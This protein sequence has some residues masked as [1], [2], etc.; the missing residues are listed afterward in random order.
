MSEKIAV[1]TGCSKGIGLATAKYLSESGYL[2]YALSRNKQSMDLEFNNIKNIITYQINLLEKLEI[3][4]FAEQIKDKKID[5]L[6]NNAGGG[7]GGGSVFAEDDPKNW[8]VAY[9]INVIAP[10]YLT[11]KLLNNLNKFSN[12]FTVSSLA[13][14]YPIHE[15]AGYSAAKRAESSMSDSLRYELAKKDIRFTEIIPGSVNTSEEI[16]PAAIEAIDIASIIKFIS[17]MPDRLNIDSIVT[18]HIYNLKR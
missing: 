12:V 14:Y 8:A 4:K 15:V 1:V 5:I 10:M 11:R 6:V 17:E 2:V 7:G 9:N 18:T 16:K 3:D 13:G